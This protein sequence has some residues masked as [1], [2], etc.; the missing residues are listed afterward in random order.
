MWL[1]TNTKGVACFLNLWSEIIVFSSE[2]VWISSKWSFRP[3]FAY[4]VYAERFP[5]HVAFT[6]VPLFLFCPTSVPLLWRI[7][8]C[9]H[10]HL[11]KYCER[12]TVA[13]K[14]LGKSGAVRIFYWIYNFEPSAWRWLDEY[15]TLD[16][17]FYNPL[18]KQK[19][20]DTAATP[21]FSS[22]S[23]SSRKPLLEI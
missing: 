13:T 19:I 2:F 7:C 22:L 5:L 11:R 15:V 14:W 16:K 9:T 18:F 3:G 4:L 23:H 6:G 10:I 12:I 1:A 17:T 8:I 21:S 20:V